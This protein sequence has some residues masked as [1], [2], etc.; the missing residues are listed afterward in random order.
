MI[1]ET[2]SEENGG[3]KAIWI[4]D[5]L[6]TQ[7]PGRYRQVKAFVWFNWR[8]Y[9]NGYW[10]PWPIESS[11]SAQAAFASGISSSYYVAGGSSAS[12]PPLSKI[13]PP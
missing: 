4:T 5:A 9:E 10:W 8:I 7:L 12:L 1:G 6:T 3:S 2:S 11:A 13:A